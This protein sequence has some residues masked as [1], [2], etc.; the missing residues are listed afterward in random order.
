[1]VS[2]TVVFWMFVFTFALVG[3]MRGWAQEL[4]ISFSVVLALAFIAVLENLLPFISESLAANPTMDYIVRM[5]VLL[6]MVFFGYQSP[7][8]SRIAKGIDKRD[9]LTD[10]ILGFIMGAISGYMVYGTFWSFANSAAYPFIK[11]YIIPPSPQVPG[12]QAA[13][14]LLEWMPPMWLGESPTIYIAVVLAFI[15]VIVVF[16]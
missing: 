11:D 5:S 16:I 2:M 15:F 10:S 1:M 7:K 6:F 4:L 14:W 12:G 9:R 3:M 8:F 13:L